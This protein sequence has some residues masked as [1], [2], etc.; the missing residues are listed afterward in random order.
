[1]NTE[2]KNNEAKAAVKDTENAIS[3]L[4]CKERE[5]HG[6]LMSPYS[7]VE[8]REWAKAGLDEIENYKDFLATLLS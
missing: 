8:M 6:V 4:L 1:M 2:I 7:S 5:L 3:R